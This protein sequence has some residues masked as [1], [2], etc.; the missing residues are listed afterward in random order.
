MVSKSP[1][2]S[3]HYNAIVMTQMNEA[4]INQCLFKLAFT[5]YT[6]WYTDLVSRLYNNKGSTLY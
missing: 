1:V 5:Q 6:Q 2:S 3:Q 4:K